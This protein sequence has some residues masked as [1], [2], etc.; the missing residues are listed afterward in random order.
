MTNPNYLIKV[1]IDSR[2][3]RIA[4]RAQVLS[5]LEQ[6]SA[7]ARLQSAVATHQP[8]RLSFGALLYLYYPKIHGINLV[9]LQNIPPLIQ[10]LGRS[11]H[12]NIGLLQHPLSTIGLSF[13]GIL[14]SLFLL[15]GMPDS[16]RSRTPR[17]ES[18]P[19]HLRSR[20]EFL[21]R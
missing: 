1:R 12:A 6:A 8:R 17:H 16:D 14:Q 4:Y 5:L 18:A 10:R 11:A 21:S 2:S 13:V 7:D 3:G 20:C 9:L 15:I 19:C